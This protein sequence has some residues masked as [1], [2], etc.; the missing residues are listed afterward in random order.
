[1]PILM[2]LKNKKIKK[3]KINSRNFTYDSITFYSSSIF[4][5]EEIQKKNKTRQIKKNHK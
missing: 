1:M 2:A 4:I 5:L 3:H